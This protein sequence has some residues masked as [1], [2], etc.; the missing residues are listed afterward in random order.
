MNRIIV[1]F[2]SG[3]GKA[4]RIKN[5]VF[6]PTYKYYTRVFIWVLIVST[7]FELTPLIGMWAVLFGILI[8]YIFLTTH[9]I[10]QAILNPFES[11]PNGI[12]LDQ[13]TRTIEINLLEAL[14]EKGI[15]EPIQSIKNEY[16]M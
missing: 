11:K 15:P 3:M 14:K 1:N 10:G 4:E 9:A 12:P 2:C 13:I 5:T 16:V 6:P 7:T 8:G